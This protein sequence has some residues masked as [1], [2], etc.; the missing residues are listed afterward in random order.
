MPD[1][2]DGALAGTGNSSIR[3]CHITQPGEGRWFVVGYVDAQNGFGALIRS[4]YACRASRGSGNI[5]VE[6]VEIE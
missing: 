3:P 1:R 5:Q 4:Y 6:N 2:G